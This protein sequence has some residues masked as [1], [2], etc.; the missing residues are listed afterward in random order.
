M[1]E[2]SLPTLYGVMSDVFM[3][4]DF[5]FAPTMSAKDVPGWDSLNHSVL[6]MELTS[7]TGLELA[8][9]KTAQLKTIGDLHEYILARLAEAPP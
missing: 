8:P 1:T 6:M 7:L 2:Y 4:R 3:L 5:E 9:D